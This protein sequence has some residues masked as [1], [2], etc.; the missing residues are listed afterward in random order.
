MSSLGTVEQYKVAIGDAN[1]NL[2]AVEDATG[3][4]VGRF[5]KWTT[6]YLQLLRSPLRTPVERLLRAYDLDSSAI[7]EQVKAAHYALPN[8]QHVV[9]VAKK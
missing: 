1:F 5:R 7:T 6:L 2:E 4:S 9:L 3:H 8:L